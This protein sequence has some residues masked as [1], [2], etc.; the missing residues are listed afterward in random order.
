MKNKASLIAI[1]E[2]LEKDLKRCIEY[3]DTEE[4]AFCYGYLRSSVINAI[5]LQYGDYFSEK[6]REK[7]NELEKY[8]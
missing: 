6:Y 8:L 5:S 4:I 1:F 7:R 2:E 3:E